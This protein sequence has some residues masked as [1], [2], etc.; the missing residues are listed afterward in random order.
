M[1]ELRNAY[2]GRKS[3]ATSPIA[4]RN[5]AEDATAR[6]TVRKV[7]PIPQRVIV[8]DGEMILIRDDDFVV[9]S[10]QDADRERGS[11]A[12]EEIAKNSGAAE[13]WMGDDAIE[14]RGEAAQTQEAICSQ[15]ESGAGAMDI[16]P[17]RPT[18]LAKGRR[19][20]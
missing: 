5:V 6:H 19:R 12:S 9:A 17:P 7:N 8:I 2:H 16:L 3:R 4:R 14:E 15:Y 13:E 11:A 18:H 1:G 10:P 20:Q